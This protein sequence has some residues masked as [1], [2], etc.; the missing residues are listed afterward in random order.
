MIFIIL[1]Q[2]YLIARNVKYNFILMFVNKC[3]LLVQNKYFIKTL[4]F[5]I[6]KCIIS[7]S[8]YKIDY[9]MNKKLR[10]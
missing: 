9:F 7:L 5:T 1:L 6:E 10:N 4:F 3:Y 2:K 8:I